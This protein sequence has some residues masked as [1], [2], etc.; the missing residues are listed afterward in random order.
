MSYIKRL[1]ERGETAVLGYVEEGEPM[2]NSI[3]D[4][5][6]RDLAVRDAHQKLVDCAP[7]AHGLTW[8]LHRRAQAVRRAQAEGWVVLYREM[9][10]HVYGA[11]MKR[12]DPPDPDAV[13]EWVKSA[14]SENDDT[15][16]PGK[17]HE[18]I[19]RSYVD[20]THMAWIHSGR[21]RDV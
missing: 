18:D 6:E 16:V 7:D 11:V 9:S 10:G 20:P 15:S 8:V 1:A 3:M 12:E 13:Y 4:V 5:I 2:V 17:H 19:S 21:L 14:A